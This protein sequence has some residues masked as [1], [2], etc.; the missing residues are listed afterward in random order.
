MQRV[1][2]WRWFIEEYSPKLFY[3]QGQLNVL[4]DA[5]SQLPSFSGDKGMEGKSAAPLAPPVSLEDAMHFGELYDCL[6]YLP[7][8][9][10]YFAAADHI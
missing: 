6:R 7:E 5:I 4:A 2:H 10:S 9:Q 1:M 8:M 3:L